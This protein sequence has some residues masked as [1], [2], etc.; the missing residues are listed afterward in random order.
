M[1]NGQG[2]VDKL[3]G[4]WK[5]IIWIATLIPVI[6]IVLNILMTMVMPA[7]FKKE[8]FPNKAKE[9]NK[10][11]WIA[12]GVAVLINGIGYLLFGGG[13]EAGAAT[14]LP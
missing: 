14:L 5:A 10:H 13:E 11:G 2:Q 3:E 12:F 8:G 1:A 9:F 7:K 4:K 6:G